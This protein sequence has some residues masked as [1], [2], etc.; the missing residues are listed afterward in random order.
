MR[1]SRAQ[2]I[3]IG[4][5]LELSAHGLG[6]FQRISPFSSSLGG[7]FSPLT[8]G[9]GE[10]G[11]CVHGGAGGVRVGYE[12]F[13]GTGKCDRCQQVSPLLSRRSRSAPCTSLDEL[14]SRRGAG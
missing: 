7:M 10:E 1:V 12:W 2:D 5:L 3:C 6:R 14:V 13:E 11:G 4:T 9:K 8:L